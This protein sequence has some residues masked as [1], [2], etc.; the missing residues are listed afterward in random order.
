ME[1]KLE[2]NGK[3]IS[4]FL[5]YKLVKETFLVDAGD[6]FNYK[7]EPHSRYFYSLE[8]VPANIKNSNWK[9]FRE[10]EL[11]DSNSDYNNFEFNF[12]TSRLFDAKFKIESLGYVCVFYGNMC[13]IQD[14]VSFTKKTSSPEYYCERFGEKLNCVY[15]CISEFIEWYVLYKIS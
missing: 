9:E 5:G 10:Y 6:E 13:F 15:D 8:N 12:N 11:C 14:Q 2:S 1:E 7:C 4:E 3:I